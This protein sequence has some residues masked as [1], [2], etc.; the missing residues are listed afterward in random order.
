MS[1][2]TCYYCGVELTKHGDT[3]VTWDHKIPRAKG[4]KGNDNYVLA[5]FRCNQDK[6]QLEADE[7]LAVL[8]YRKQKLT[9]TL[10]RLECVPAGP[11]QLTYQDYAF[12]YE[13]GVTYEV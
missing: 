13:I 9:Q 12:L 4:G 6:G 2:G 10:E 8:R 5:C 7:F 1:F 3:K 11:Q